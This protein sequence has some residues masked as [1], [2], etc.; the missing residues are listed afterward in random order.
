MLAGGTS[1]SL[2]NGGATVCAVKLAGSPTQVIIPAAR[3]TD[4]GKDFSSGIG[5]LM[6]PF[7]RKAPRK[8]V[9]TGNCMVFQHTADGHCVGRCYYSTYGG[10]CHLH[11]DVSAWIEYGDWPNDYDLDVNPVRKELDVLRTDYWMSDWS[12]PIIILGFGVLWFIVMLL[13]L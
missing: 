12:G 10:V 13:V 1:P 3:F 11:G 2:S 6:W 5:P 4:A 7:K 9:F 8:R